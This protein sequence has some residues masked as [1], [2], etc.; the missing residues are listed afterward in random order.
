MRDG[1]GVAHVS[2]DDG[3]GITEWEFTYPVKVIGE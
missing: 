1:K 3:F 2:A